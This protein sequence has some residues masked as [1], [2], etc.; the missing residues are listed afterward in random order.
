MCEVCEVAKHPYLNPREYTYI[1][2]F[3]SFGW[4]VLFFSLTFRVVNANE[5][6]YYFPKPFNYVSN[7]KFDILN[8][9]Y[10]LLAFSSSITQRLPDG[11]FAC[12]WVLRDRDFHA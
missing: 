3:V 7:D 1:A 5:E 4:F 10:S 12:G 2:I 9:R 6:V 8:K 11:G